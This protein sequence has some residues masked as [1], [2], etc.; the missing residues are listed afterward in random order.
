MNKTMLTDYYEFT[1]SEALFK[2]GRKDDIAVFDAFYRQHLFGLG[3]EL[4]GGVD[5]LIDFIKNIHFTDDDIR[6][7]KEKG[8]Y[9][10]EFLEY[11]R[12]FKFTGS[13]YAVPD[14]TPIFP[15]EPIVTVVAPIIEAQ[16]VETFILNQL[17]PSILFMTAARRVVDAAKNIPVM[18][19]G[20]RRALGMDASIIAS[21]SAYIAGCASTSNTLVG[22]KYGIPI[23]GTMAHSFVE[24]YDNEYDAFLAY[25]KTHPNNCVF[26]VDTYDVLRSG[27]KNA[28][29]VAQDYL[30]PNG[31]RLKGI[32]IDSGDLAYLTKEAKRMLVEAS[33]AD[34]TI[35]V[36]NGLTENEIKSLLDQGAVIDS[37]G[38][39]DNIVLPDYAR[40][41]CV[42]KLAALYK[43][44]DIT[45]LIPK[46]KVSEAEVKTTN[47]SLKTIYR[48][49]D[50]DTNYALGDV[51]A[52]NNE[53]IP[54]EE[55]TFID[56]NNEHR[57]KTITNYHVRKLQ[58]PIFLNGKLVYHDP[59]IEEKRLLVNREMATLYPEIKRSVKPYP[60]FVDLTPDLLELKKSMI[61]EIKGYARVRK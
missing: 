46:I 27:V 57:T 28:I 1:M 36:S 8:L 53:I 55:F 7:L 54:Q 3:Y 37:I 13:I 17:N 25:A 30:I 41:G 50:K 42:Y 2:D 6:Y 22:E 58:V 34:A 18:E 29:K 11:L 9:S 59:T 33:M 21:K 40:V 51:L 19:F 10:A 39:G 45:S 48:F 16:I 44:G 24:S 15:N 61:K 5:A 31:Y 35:C 12:N 60:Y 47:P 52:L 43:N 20:A 4:M 32:R 26:L 14:G 49:Y 56:P 23:S 38:L